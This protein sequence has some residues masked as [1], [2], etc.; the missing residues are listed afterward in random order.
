MWF[1]YIRQ[2][3]KCTAPI[4]KEPLVKPSKLT[5]FDVGKVV[6]NAKNRQICKIQS[7]YKAGQI[8]PT[9]SVTSKSGPDLSDFRNFKKDF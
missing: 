8:V 5:K 2:I 7:I 6:N 9:Q 4:A 3:F 1:S